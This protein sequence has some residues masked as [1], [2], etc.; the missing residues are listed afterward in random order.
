MKSGIVAAILLA[1]VLPSTAAGPTAEELAERVTQLEKSV[2]EITKALASLAEETEVKVAVPTKADDAKRPKNEIV[3]LVKADG[4]MVV[5][6]KSL[7][8][9]E[10]LE[11]LKDRAKQ[12]QSQAVR[13]QGDAAVG[14]G[15][16][17]EVIEI[18]QKAALWNISFGTERKG[19]SKPADA[20]TK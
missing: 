1:T 18:C 12:N 8:P 20:K 13:V 16:I 17:V 14:Y 5:E 7:S 4:G 2:E 6:G 15:R 19:T 3:I 10:L 11:L 9:D